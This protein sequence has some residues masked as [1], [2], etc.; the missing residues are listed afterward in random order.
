[1]RKRKAHLVDN[2]VQHADIGYLAQQAY[3]LVAERLELLQR[4]LVE[5]AGGDRRRRGRKEQRSEQQDSHAR[6]RGGTSRIP[7]DL[8]EDL[9]IALHLPRP[10]PH[11]LVV[12]WGAPDVDDSTARE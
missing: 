2:L 4:E 6:G 9:V 7:L 11:V 5:N 1:V 3:Q 10:L 8:L 12:C